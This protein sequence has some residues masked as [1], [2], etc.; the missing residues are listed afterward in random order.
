MKKHT[1]NKH[2]GLIIIKCNL[3]TKCNQ[4]GKRRKN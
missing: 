2:R 1:S 4:K 3:D